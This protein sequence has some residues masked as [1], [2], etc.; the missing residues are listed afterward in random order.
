[1]SSPRFMKFLK[2]FVKNHSRPEAC[3]L[4]RNSAEECACHCSGYMKYGAEIGVRYT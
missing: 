1:M 2:G 3:I 4:E